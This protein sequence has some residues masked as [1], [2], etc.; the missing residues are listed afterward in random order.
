MYLINNKYLLKHLLWLLKEEKNF[1]NNYS[2]HNS[3]YNLKNHVYYIQTV[4][5]LI[6]KLEK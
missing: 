4:Y 2:N 1:Y 3:Y 5:D 6:S